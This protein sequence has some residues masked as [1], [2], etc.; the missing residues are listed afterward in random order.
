MPSSD[1]GSSDS[2]NLDEDVYEVE[3]ILES[4][5][6]NGTSIFKIKVCHE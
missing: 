4:R 3:E 5:M 2:T 6:E 1:N